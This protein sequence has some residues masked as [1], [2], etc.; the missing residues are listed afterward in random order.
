MSTSEDLLRTKLWAVLWPEIEKPEF[1]IQVPTNMSPIG[2][3]QQT[4]RNFHLATWAVVKILQA[5]HQTHV[6]THH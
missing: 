1:K 6:H 3:N 2:Q 4:G 5:T